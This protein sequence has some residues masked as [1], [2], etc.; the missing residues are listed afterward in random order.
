MQPFKDS[1]RIDIGPNSTTTTTTKNP[2]FIIIIKNISRYIERELFPHMLFTTAYR[3][4]LCP[5]PPAS[6]YFTC[7][8]QAS[9]ASRRKQPAASS[10][11]NLSA[12]EH[13]SAILTLGLAHPPSH[14]SDP[15]R[16][17]CTAAR[18]GRSAQSSRRGRRVAAMPDLK[19]FDESPQQTQTNG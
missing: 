15:T 11:T 3:F 16:T 8:C 14:Q 7:S 13:R 9:A 18:K 1:H 4:F 2:T 17:A 12:S 5:S 10:Q 6:H 19:T